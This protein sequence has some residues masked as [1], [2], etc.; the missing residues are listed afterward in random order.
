MELLGI[1]LV[2]WASASLEPLTL[3]EAARLA[4]DGAPS[5]HRAAD[6]AEA[7]LARRDAAR[8]HLFPSLVAD[9]GVLSSTDPVDAFS[10]ALK[11]ERFSS[12]SFFASDPNHPASTTDWSGSLT[13]SW[14]VDLF[15]SARGR[16][17]AAESAAS[18]A[19]YAARRAREAAALA[20]IEAFARGRI[21]EDSLA[22]LSEREVD[23]RQDVSLAS[24]LFDQGMTTAADPARARATLAEVRAQESGARAALTEARAALAVLIGP[25]DASRPLANLPDPEPVEIK[26]QEDKRDD[27]LAAELSASAAE[28]AAAAVRAARYPEVFL[29]GRYETHAPRPGDRWGDSS[30]VL[31][32]L[33]VALF[34]SGAVRAGIAEASASAREAQDAAEQARR[35]ATSEIVAARAAVEAADAKEES[36][37]SARDAAHE[38]ASV[39]QA[40]YEEGLGRLSDLLES[41]GAELAARLAASVARAQRSVARSR[42][43]F[44]QGFALCGEEKK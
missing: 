14:T 10:L 41:R 7:A 6:A 44:A 37:L 1:A 29:R 13:V 20:A 40:R 15:G 16:A 34:A 23:A 35:T 3:S 32:G 30:S 21:A 9:A 42:L 31:G 36:Y 17:R 26:A 43:R 28:Q 38:A 12:A 4:A 8:A 2:L 18:S 33:R 11:Q 27:V 22:I 25:D 5:V 24:S 19:G 39:Q